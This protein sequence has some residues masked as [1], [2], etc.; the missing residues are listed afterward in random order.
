[1]DYVNYGTG[2]RMTESKPIVIS[3]RERSKIGLRI[4]YLELQKKY[5]WNFFE[6]KSETIEEGIINLKRYLRIN[7]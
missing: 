7:N 1:M 4:R 3:K 2:Y 6:A 5:L